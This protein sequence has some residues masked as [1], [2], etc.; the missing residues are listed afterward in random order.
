MSNYE[1]AWNKWKKN[2]RTEIENVKKNQMEIMQLKNI[3]IEMKTQ[4]MDS[5]EER[6][7]TEDGISELENRTIEIT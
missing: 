6:E 2:L 4:L 3:I 5:T 1:R 7:R